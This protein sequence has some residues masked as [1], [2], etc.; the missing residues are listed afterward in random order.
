LT[1]S[2]LAGFLGEFDACKDEDCGTPGCCHV[3]VIIES[4]YAGNFNAPGLNDQEG[5][6]VAGSSTNTPA[7]GIYPG[8]GVYTAGFVNGLQDPDADADTD[9]PPDGVDPAEAHASADSAVQANPRS[10]KGKQ[11]S[12]SEGN[13]CECKCPCVPGIDVDKWVWG[14]G[15]WVNEIE[16]ELDQLVEFRI[17][18][19]ND[20]ECRDIV[21]IEL[22]DYLPP[23]LEPAYQYDPVI[24]YDGVPQGPRPPDDIM[25]TQDGL[26][27]FWNLD[28]LPPLAPGE[29]ITIEYPAY[30]VYPGPNINEVFASAHCS[31]DYTNIVTDQDTATVWVQQEEI[32]PEDVLYGYLDTE[33]HCTC[34]DIFCTDCDI[35]IWFGAEDISL[36]LGPY[37]V[38]SV[39]L[40]V[41]EFWWDGSGPISTPQWDGH[42]EIEGAGCGQT[43]N[44]EVVATNSIDLEVHVFGTVN[45]PLFCD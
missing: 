1:P 40:Y 32:P 5:M 24:Y 38:T 25:Q 11:Q 17:D 42:T 20:G 8:G 6:V 7:Q 36:L 41:N 27:L 28:E 33:T 3:S 18:I 29:S 16:A 35:D 10:K 26:Q 37:P 19:E 14:G 31:Y 22:L 23:C 4:C 44:L 15:M 2:A 45:T 21:D 13:W 34:D 30:A 39:D 43:Y 12:W 9:D